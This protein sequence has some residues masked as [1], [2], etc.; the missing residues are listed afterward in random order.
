ML[1]RVDDIIMNNFS[2]I[3]NKFLGEWELNAKKYYTGII[4]N[5]YNKT[6]IKNYSIGKKYIETLYNNEYRTKD[7]YKF[8]DFA[9][10]LGLSNEE[11]KEFTYVNNSIGLYKSQ[12]NQRYGALEKLLVRSKTIEKACILLDSLLERELKSKKEILIKKINAKC[13][14]II[15][16]SN[17]KVDAIGNL[18]GYVI[19][20][21]GKVKVE[22]AYKDKEKLNYNLFLKTIETNK[23]EEKD[24]KEE[25][26]GIL[27]RYIL[28]INNIDIERHTK[29][30]N[31][32]KDSGFDKYLLKIGFKFYK[33]IL[34]RDIYMYVDN[35]NR[36]LFFS[37]TFCMQVLNKDE[38]KYRILYC[39][40]EGYTLKEVESIVNRLSNE[41]IQLV[42]AMN[43]KINLDNF[44]IYK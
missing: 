8:K 7:Y 23:M 4:N 27:R 13:E 1:E 18:K 26:D 20:K 35:R 5:Y 43:L 32:F 25:L 12:F 16:A 41:C 24:K 29:L 33:R 44:Q 6:N 17:L 9:K 22:T 19:G 21:N 31:K 11:L 30:E 10:S 42:R 36:C 2:E 34:G 40:E 14:D 38:L 39:L 28:K 3:I 37:Y 15:D